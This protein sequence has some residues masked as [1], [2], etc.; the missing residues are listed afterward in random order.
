[1][2][3]I[4]EF[5]IVK[6]PGDSCS[7]IICLSVNWD[8]LCTNVKQWLVLQLEHSVGSV[9]RPLSISTVVV[10]WQTMH[11]KKASLISGIIFEVR[12][13]IPLI[14]ISWSISGKWKKYNQYFLS[15][16]SLLTFGIERSHI[17]SFFS[18]KR[19]NLNLMFENGSWITFVKHFIDSHIKSGYDFLRI[20]NQ[21]TIKVGVE[22]LQMRTIH[23][24]KWFFQS[25]NLKTGKT[26][27]SFRKT[28]C[29]KLFQL[30][31]HPTFE[32]IKV[33]LNS[34]RLFS[35]LLRHLDQWIAIWI[36]WISLCIELQIH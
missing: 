6:S 31:P 27:F 8:L 23:I 2:I 36:A 5:I 17:L 16:N 24:Q 14:V 22:C 9:M 7:F 35:H 29:W 30:L 11:L 12:I 33:H 26:S 3:L 4:N 18:I 1:M 28:Y 20:A 10:N 19:S 25:M 34:Y 32:G 13:T 21:L 15:T